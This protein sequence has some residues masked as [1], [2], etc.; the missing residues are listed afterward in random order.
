MI[1]EA[2][3]PFVPVLPIRSGNLLHAGHGNA[4]VV[5]LLYVACLCAVADPSDHSQ[6]LILEPDEPLDV[7]V[8]EPTA[9]ETV[10]YPPVELP[11]NAYPTNA[12]MANSTVVTGVSF[13]GPLL[14]SICRCS[15][16]ARSHERV[17]RERRMCLT[18]QHLRPTPRSGISGNSGRRCVCTF[19]C[20]CDKG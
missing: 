8:R 16:S 5:D 19:L 2:R 11:V 14:S 12:S 3:T 18:R 13:P 17:F 10:E 9:I 1:H 4:R 20:A 7:R 15:S 6:S